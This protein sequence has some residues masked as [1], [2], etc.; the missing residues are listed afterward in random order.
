[1]TG[2][3]QWRRRV[4]AGDG[5]DGRREAPPEMGSPPEMID[6]SEWERKFRER[7]KLSF[8]DEREWENICN[9]LFW[10]CKI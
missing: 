6:D 10:E 7:V 8:F 3:E 2:V 4:A 5:E 9:L 1:M